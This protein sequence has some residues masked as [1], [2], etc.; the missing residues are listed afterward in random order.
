MPARTKGRAKFDFRGRPF[1]WWVDADRYLRISSLDKRFIIAAP[2]GTAIDMP[3]VIE[4]IG[5]EFPGLDPS[6]RRPIRLV[7]PESDSGECPA[8]GTSMGAWVDELLRWSFDPG[9]ALIRFDGPIR[10]S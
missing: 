6:E 3:P 1:V 10:F 7:V 8:P 5:Q 4:V 2:M 9:R